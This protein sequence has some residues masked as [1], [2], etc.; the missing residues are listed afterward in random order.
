M[1][2]ILTFISSWFLWGIYLIAVCLT[3]IVTPKELSYISDLTSQAE[4]QIDNKQAAEA[5]V[6]ELELRDDHKKINKELKR[7]TRFCY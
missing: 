3:M 1:Q 4:I 7:R 5:T 6:K 2:Y